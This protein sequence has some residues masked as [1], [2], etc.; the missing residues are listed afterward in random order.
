MAKTVGLRIKAKTPQVREPENK[1][2]AVNGENKTPKT[3]GKN[4]N[5]NK[6]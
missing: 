4:S 2:P 1:T 5:K 6:K 3:N